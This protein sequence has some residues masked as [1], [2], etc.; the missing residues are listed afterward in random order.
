MFGVVLA[1]K[2]AFKAAGMAGKL[3]VLF[4]LYKYK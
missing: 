1:G 2:E 4:I 3:V